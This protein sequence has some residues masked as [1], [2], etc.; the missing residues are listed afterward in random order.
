MNLF[1][2]EGK[3]FSALEYVHKIKQDVEDWFLAQF[4]QTEES[5]S[6]NG[7]EGE[8]ST[9]LMVND[10]GW[11]PPI[12]GWLKCN[13]GGAWSKRN[14]LAGGGWVLRDEE[15]AVLLHSRRAFSNI[16]AK[17]EANLQCKLSYL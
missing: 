6:S 7:Q 2:F 8:C 15:G 14:S 16:K 3:S 4:I 11:T 9:T 13:V 1:F 17:D 12:Q 10:D 5:S